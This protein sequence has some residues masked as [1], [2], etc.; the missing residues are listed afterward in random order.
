MASEQNAV[1]ILGNGCASAECLK[2]LRESGYRGQ[3]HVFSDGKWPVYNPTLTT[4]YLAGKITFDGLFP[5][6]SDE[7]FYRLYGATVHS[8]SPIVALDTEAKLVAN[9]AGL[10]IKYDQCLIATGASPFIPPIEGGKSHRIYTMRT[11]DDAIRLREAL[12][13]KPRKAIVVG[14]SLVGVKMVEL[15]QMIG[16]EVCLADLAEHVFP[17]AAH[18][19][20]AEVIEKRMA[21]K[22]IKFRLGAGI[23][24][25]EETHDGVRAHFQ[26]NA[27]GEEADL[28]IMCIGVRAN[29]S[30]VD[31]KYVECRQ[32]ILIDEY[33]QTSAPGVYAAGDV[34]QG[35]NLLSG[36]Q[37]IIGLWANARYQGRTAGRNMA[38]L[39]EEFAGNIPH[40]ISH[41]MNMDFVGIGSVQDYDRTET[42]SEGL[43]FM[44]IFWKNGLLAGANFLDAYTETG[45]IK[46]VLTKRLLQGQP[47]SFSRLPVQVSH[48]LMVERTLREVESLWP[49]CRLS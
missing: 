15:F 23:A 36:E 42:W 44:Q 35:Q 16:M 28:L 27:E 46:N 20:C 40:C 7:S 38:G 41:F 12:G 1:T 5:Y 31:H 43:K 39:A 10:E 9:E 37:Q 25:V 11:V 13:V 4:Y 2:A 33:M 24:K 45:I 48:N 34:A 14:A 3:I 29:I 49:H 18:A 22:G 19:D 6:G 30:F 8:N 32:G 47:A 17:L 26:N 21:Q